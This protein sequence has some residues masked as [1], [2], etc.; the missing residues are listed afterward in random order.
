VGQ[1]YKN[2]PPEQKEKYEKLAA[3]KKEEYFEKWKVFS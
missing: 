2:L 1:I 3:L